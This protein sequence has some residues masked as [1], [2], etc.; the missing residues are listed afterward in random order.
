MM[1]VFPGDKNRDGVLAKVCHV[2]NF[3]DYTISAFISE[4]NLQGSKEV[5]TVD[6]YKIVRR[7][8]GSVN[9][10]DY[11]ARVRTNILKEDDDNIDKI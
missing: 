7:L 10:N 6:Q 1:L 3:Y 8:D 5:F 11:N 4:G 2:R 9:P